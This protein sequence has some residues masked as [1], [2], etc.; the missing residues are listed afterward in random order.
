MKAIETRYAGCRF[1]SRLEARWAVFFDTL[2]IEWLYESEG[3]DVSGNFEGWTHREP[4][5]YLPDFYLP[6]EGLWVEVKGR[7]TTEELWR[8]CHAACFL[9]ADPDGTPYSDARRNCDRLVLLGEIPRADGRWP[10]HPT[11]H[12]HKGDISISY[13]RFEELGTAS[14]PTDWDPIWCDA[15]DWMAPVKLTLHELTTPMVMRQHDTP[16]H[17]A[18]AYTAARS[19]R[20][21]HGESGRPT[22]CS[23]L[24]PRDL[25]R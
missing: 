13:R 19:A 2:G 8:I 6:G 20:F 23:P 16:W 11:F 17:V 22:N 5:L 21:E 18:A 1:R 12:F 9:P 4:M 3:W 14:I 10:L 24:H 15:P 25:I 7:L